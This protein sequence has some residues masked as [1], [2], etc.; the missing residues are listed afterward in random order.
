MFIRVLQR[1]SH[2]YADRQHWY[3]FLLDAGYSSAQVG[4]VLS[5]APYS[6]GCANL[7]ADRY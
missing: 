2:L 3:M 1:K 6:S 7:A 4:F 5:P